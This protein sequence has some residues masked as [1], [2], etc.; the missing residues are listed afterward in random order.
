MKMSPIGARQ[1]VSFVKPSLPRF[2]AQPLK[3][4]AFN[5]VFLRR[6]F[7]GIRRRATAAE[8]ASQ[9]AKSVGKICLRFTEYSTAFIIVAIAGFFLYDVTLA[10]KSF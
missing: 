7:F 6:T 4:T 10:M 5:S 2:K 1:F 9:T 3:E 8:T